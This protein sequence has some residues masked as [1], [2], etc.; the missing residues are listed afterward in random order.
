MLPTLILIE[1]RKGIYSYVNRRDILRHLALWKLVEYMKSSGVWEGLRKSCKWS[2]VLNASRAS[3]NRSGRIL[4][5]FFCLVARFCE[6]KEIMDKTKNKTN[7]TPKHKQTKNK[8]TKT[9]EIIQDKQQ[10]QQ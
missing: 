7:K 2:A 9:L 6:L 5:F 10:K 1:K 3:F 4:C 8:Q